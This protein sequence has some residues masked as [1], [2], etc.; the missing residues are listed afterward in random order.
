MIIGGFEPLSLT[1]FP[2]RVACIV[3]TVG[4]NLRCGY[5]YN[6]DLITKKWFKESDRKEY[7]VD[8]VLKYIKKNKNI[9]RP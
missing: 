8:K 5:C 9:C 1:D 2:G 6:K 3:F 7:C 4:C